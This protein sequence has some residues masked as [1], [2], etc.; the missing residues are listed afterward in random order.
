MSL[1]LE[2]PFLVLHAADNIAVARHH[3]DAGVT[4]S[5]PS[6]GE[7]VTTREAIEL[8]H[9]V[10]LQPISAGEP[11]RKFGQVIGFTTADISAGSWVH[12]HNMGMGELSQT[13]EIGVEAARSNHRPN[14]SG[15]C[16][17]GWTDRNPELCRHHQYRELL[18]DR[19]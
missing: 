3:V 4:F 8:G 5:I 2:S 12:M 18:G 1:S 9:K 11:V 17:T 19:V 16:E 13:Y 7:T 14:V 10:A 6:S 15:D